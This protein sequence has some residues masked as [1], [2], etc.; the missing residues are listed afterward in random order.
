M[1]AME[2]GTPQGS[3]ISPLLANVALN[4]LDEAWA[5][6]GRA[7]WECWSGTPTTSSPC[8]PPASRPMPARELAATV[9]ADARV[10]TASRA[11]PGSCTSPEAPRA[12]TSWAFII[13]CESPGKRRGRWYLQKWPT[14]RA[15][16]SIRGKIR[17]RTDRSLRHASGGAGRSRTSTPAAGLGGRTSA[18][19]TPH[20]SSRPSTAYVNQRLAMLASTKHGLRGWNWTTRFTPR[21]DQQASASIASTEPSNPRLRM[22]AGERCR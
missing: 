19:E 13:R 18:T 20:G 15:M 14:P 10:A 4:V 2:A 1:S 16:A 11:D 6:D 9:L 7:G 17:E 8:A 21:V 12:S 3:P 5:S 22:P